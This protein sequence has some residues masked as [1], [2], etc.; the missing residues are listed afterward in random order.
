MCKLY[1][2]AKLENLYSIP[3]KGVRL[4]DLTAFRGLYGFPKKGKKGFPAQRRNE[5]YPA[6]FDAKGTIHATRYP[7]GRCAKIYASVGE[8]DIDGNTIEEGEQG[9]YYAWYRGLHMLPGAE[10]A[11]LYEIRP[12]FENFRCKD[13]SFK[14]KFKALVQEANGEE[15]YEGDEK[16]SVD[17]SNQEVPKIPE[18]RSDA[19]APV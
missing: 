12:S 10:G 13:F 19:D 14:K 4:D 1:I 2:N 3:A 18:M 8:I 11:H 6:E 15:Y 17:A 9:W 5:C 7:L 16:N